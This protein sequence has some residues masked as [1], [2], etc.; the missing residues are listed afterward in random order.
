[1]A[2]HK[3]PSSAGSTASAILRP[4]LARLLVLTVLLG[5]CAGSVTRTVV[6][7]PSPI[8]TPRFTPIPAAP[9]QTPAPT[10]AAPSIAGKITRAGQPFAGAFLTFGSASL[11]KPCDFV[12][13]PID[14]TV[15]ADGTF[16]P[17]SRNLGPGQW[18]VVGRAN[19]A[20]HFWSKYP[21]FG[22][23]WFYPTGECETAQLITLKAGEQFNLTWD[24]R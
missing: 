1:M 10:V 23:I 7:S 6:S 24:I 18:Y 5:A 13:G 12:P 20:G 9:T 16:G 8:P 21:N 2:S 3:E 17:F 11:G 4:V 15:R 19:V 14:I 22:S